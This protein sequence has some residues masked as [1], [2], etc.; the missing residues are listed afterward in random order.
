MKNFLALS[1][2][3]TTLAAC[4]DTVIEIPDLPGGPDTTRAQ[5][6][7][8][9][10]TGPSDDPAG[11]TFTVTD[12]PFI[13]FSNTSTSATELSFTVQLSEDGSTLT[14]NADG[15]EIVLTRTSGTTFGDP[16]IGPVAVSLTE[17][18]DFLPVSIYNVTLGLGTDQ[19]VTGSF[20]VG[21]DT[22]PATVA[23]TTGQVNYTGTALLYAAQSQS[24]NSEAT[25]I[26]GTFDLNADFDAPQSVSGTMSFDASTSDPNLQFPAFSLDVL[27]GAIDGNR[28]S[29]DIAVQVGSSLG[30]DRTLDGMDYDGR[31]YG[32]DA[33]AVAG[34][35]A[36]SVTETGNSPIFL[37]GVLA[38]TN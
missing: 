7:T 27:P 36:G 26:A 25:T 38:S 2:A 22:D 6:S 30:D 16:I 5:A 17:Q 24:G 19:I 21:F 20:P 4:A 29:G 34:T 3:L 28:F 37:Q 9:Y 10:A 18:S 14:L 35:M 1:A 33:E 31:F 8:G 13:S 12:T 11:V 15:Q 32:V 23:A